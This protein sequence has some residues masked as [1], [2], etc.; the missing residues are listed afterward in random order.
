LRS[1]PDVA[2]CANTAFVGASLMARFGIAPV[3]LR[4]LGLF[5]VHREIAE[6]RGHALARWFFHAPFARAICTLE[7]SGAEFYLPKLL[8]PGVPHDVLLNGVDR[9]NIERS[10]V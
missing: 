10:A 4:F 2:Y 6:R 3:L 8:K 5:P 1:R 9:P 7:G